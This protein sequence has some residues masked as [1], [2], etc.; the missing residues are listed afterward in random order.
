[1]CCLRSSFELA[2]HAV[3]N[4]GFSFHDEILLVSKKIRSFDQSQLLLAPIKAA[5]SGG[6]WRKADIELY[7]TADLLKAYVHG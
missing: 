2:P 5:Y 3:S 6:I 7:S 4:V 1:M